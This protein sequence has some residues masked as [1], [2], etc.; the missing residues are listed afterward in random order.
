MRIEKILIVDD[1]DLSR[2]YVSEALERNGYVVEKAEGGHKAVS[3]I[4]LTRY[5]IIFLDLKMPGLSGLDVLQKIK[6]FNKEDTVVIMMTAYGSIESAVEAMRMGAYDYVIKPISL[7]RIELLLKRVQ[8][9][10]NLIDENTYWRSKVD[11]NEVL[12][13]PIM[14][15]KSKMYKIYQNLNKIAQSKASVLIQGES[16]TGKELIAQSIYLQ[17]RRSK[18]PFIKVNCAALSES[19]LESELFGHER[20]SFTG[21]DTKRLG[22]FE[23]ANNGTLLLD[24]ISEIS[25]KIQSKLLRVLE[26][27]EFE[28]VGASKT[29]KVDVRII[30]TTNRNIPVEIEKNRFRQD[31]FFRLNVLPIIMPPLR[32][33]K[34]DIPD[35]INYF[36]KKYTNGANASIKGISDKAKDLLC[37]YYWPG[38]VRELKNLLHRCV[39]MVDSEILLPEHFENMLNVNCVPKE[40]GLKSGKSI[41]DIERVLIYKTL[42][43]THGNKTK[44]AEILDI[45]PRTLRNKLNKYKSDRSHADIDD[46]GHV[47]KSDPVTEES[48]SLSE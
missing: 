2:N 19:L 16:G 34:E 4:A 11:G 46:D 45:T 23:L 40:N 5:D 24:E 37:Q 30:A 15:E 17:S 21:A 7:D 41:G 33:R 36:L 28:R 32:E 31:L 10:Q 13:K 20:G 48:F 39:V 18:G 38:N 26:E 6:K 3:M 47:H 12:H 14:N 29:I 25:P 9:R 35:L 44:A 1:D 42:E 22:R 43:E 27:E 8:E